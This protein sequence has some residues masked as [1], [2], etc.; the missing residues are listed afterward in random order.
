M[1]GLPDAGPPIHS[2]FHTRLNCCMLAN[3]RRPQH[4]WGD[5]GFAIRIHRGYHGAQ[6]RGH[7]HAVQ[8]GASHR[9]LAE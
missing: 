1:A 2:A 8:N 6:K 4:T 5:D 7:G 9:G 3:P